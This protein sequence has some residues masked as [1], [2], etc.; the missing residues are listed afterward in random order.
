MS[1][2]NDDE[3]FEEIQ[4]SLEQEF[5]DFGNDLVETIRDRLSEPAQVFTG[6]RGGKIVIG[7]EEGEP[8]CMRTGYLRDS[9]RFEVI[10]DE[11]FFHGPS[12]SP[13][14]RSAV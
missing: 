8:P 2:Q 12:L 13:Y 11:N 9:I 10:N 5:I 4:R 14:W 6:P 7:S 3:L 1:S